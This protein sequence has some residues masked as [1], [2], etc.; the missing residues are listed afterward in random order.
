MTFGRPM[1]Q[2]V[3]HR[4]EGLR[5]VFES[6]LKA[7][8]SRVYPMQASLVG[9]VGRLYRDRTLPSY[10]AYPLYC[11]SIGSKTLPKWRSSSLRFRCA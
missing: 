9:G 2:K 6:S 10:W 4:V 3:A 5:S 1:L 8:L 7:I 11:S